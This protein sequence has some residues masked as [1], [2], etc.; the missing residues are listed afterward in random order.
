MRRKE[1]EIRDP[2]ELAA[3]M[4]EALVC[5]LAMIDG[6]VPYIVPLSFG[7]RDNAL[8]FH[9]APEGKKLE[10][11]LANPEVGFE[12][13]AGVAMVSGK[14]PCNWGVHYRSIIG[15]GRAALLTDTDEKRQ[16]LD[17]IM[18]HY[19]DGESF[20]FPDDMLARTAVIRV[21]IVAMTG[22]RSA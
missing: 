2:Q 7:Y 17:I 3:I 13:E 16:A 18:A 15:H 1:Q 20:D 10:L 6:R 14:T 8:Y 5:R 22:K 11:L 9:S 4:N 19:T 12:L 21:D